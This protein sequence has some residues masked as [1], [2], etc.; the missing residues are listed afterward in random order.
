VAHRIAQREELALLDA[1]AFAV[2]GESRRCRTSPRI[3]SSR[4]AR[5]RKNP[6]PHSC[7]GRA[8][9]IVF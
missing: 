6:S 8:M 3:L 1:R 9:R 2:T 4:Y 7:R 5:V